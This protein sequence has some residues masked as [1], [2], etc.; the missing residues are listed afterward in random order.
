MACVSG[1]QSN[2]ALRAL[3]ARKKADKK[4]GDVALGH[5][6]RKMLHLVFAVWKTG[7]PF[8]PKHYPWAQTAHADSGNSR[9][10]RGPCPIH[11]SQRPASRS[12]SVNLERNLFQCFSPKCQAH[13][14]VL[15]LWAA[16]HKLTLYEAAKHLAATFGIELPKNEQRRGTRKP[17]R[18]HTP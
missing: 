11:N 18:R 7:K 1:I 16:I 3:Y 14:N 5:C 12:F 4:R 8:D 2:P 6:M 9:Q 15:D 17:L 10:C 13:G